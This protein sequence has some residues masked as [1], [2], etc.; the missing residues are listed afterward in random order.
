MATA[1]PD[2]SLAKIGAS[3]EIRWMKHSS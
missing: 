2:V 1:L 3:K